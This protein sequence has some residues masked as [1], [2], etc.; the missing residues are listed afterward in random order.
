MPKAIQVSF[1][2]PKLVLHW[3]V[4]MVLKDFFSSNYQDS[5]VLMTSKKVSPKVIFVTLYLEI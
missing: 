2:L 4:L 3:L 5:I 1:S